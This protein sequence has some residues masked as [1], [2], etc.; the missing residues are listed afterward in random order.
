MKLMHVQGI[1]ML[2]AAELASKDVWS[3]VKGHESREQGWALF[4]NLPWEKITSSD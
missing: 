2:Y 1:V 4:E 3:R